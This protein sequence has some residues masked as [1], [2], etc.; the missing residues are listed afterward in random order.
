MLLW[1]TRTKAEK[2]GAASK[3][4]DVA[5]Q[6]ADEPKEAGESD[7]PVRQ[8]TFIYLLCVHAGWWTRV[9]MYTCVTSA[10]VYTRAHRL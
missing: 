3:N 5:E 8:L 7:G 1:C 2:L 9:T 10:G 4:F 6:R